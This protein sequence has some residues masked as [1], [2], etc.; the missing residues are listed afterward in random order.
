[1]GEGG[2]ARHPRRPH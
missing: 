2:R 1:V